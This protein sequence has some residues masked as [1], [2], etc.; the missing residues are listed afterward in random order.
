MK[1]L[2]IFGKIKLNFSHK[3]N[4]DSLNSSK[5]SVEKKICENS[6]LKVP[7]ENEDHVIIEQKQEQ[8]QQNDQ[9]NSVNKIQMRKK[10]IDPRSNR[11]SAHVSSS[12]VSNNY[13]TK[14]YS[15]DLN[16]KEITY[17]YKVLIIGNSGKLP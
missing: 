13:N 2:N 14:R 7:V 8:Q 10:K 17:I 9:Q 4:E 16:A 12:S 1:K 11:F 6:P 15:A 3:S 5:I